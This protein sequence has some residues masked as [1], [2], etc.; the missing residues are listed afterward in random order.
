[1]PAD[2]SEY[3]LEEKICRALSLTIVNVVPN[4]LH[5][6]HQIFKSV[7]QGIVNK[8]IVSGII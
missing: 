3:V 6:C 2:I 5:A 7:F 1:M 8:I 4:D